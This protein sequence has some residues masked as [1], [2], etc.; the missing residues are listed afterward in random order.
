[1]RTFN[2][3]ATTITPRVYPTCMFC[4]TNGELV[5]RWVDAIDADNVVPADLHGVPYS[6]EHEEI[7]ISDTEGMP[8]IPSA[9][10]MN[11]STAA[12]WGHAIEAITPQWRAAYIAYIEDQWIKDPQDAPS[13]QE[14]FEVF[15]GKFESFEDYADVV[16]T[17]SGMLI[18]VPDEV[19]RYFSVEDFARDLQ[20]DYTTIDTGTPDYAVWVYRNV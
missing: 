12:R 19:S 15:E 10:E 1:M 14:F 11:L 6:D 13:E 17:D 20:M 4:Y 7:W 3:D 2:A 9:G 16:V 8:I 18:G 5:G